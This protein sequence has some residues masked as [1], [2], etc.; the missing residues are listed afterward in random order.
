MSE[1]STSFILYTS[2]TLKLLF[3]ALHSRRFV[4]DLGL[5]MKRMLLAE[6]Y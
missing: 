4:L 3:F 6:I 1:D 5:F 2:T